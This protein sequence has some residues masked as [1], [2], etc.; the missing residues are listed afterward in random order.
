MAVTICNKCHQGIMSECGGKNKRERMDCTNYKKG[1]DGDCMWLR[2]EQFC[3]N[4]KAQCEC[5]GKEYKPPWDSS[6]HARKEK[7]QAEKNQEQ[8]D[9]MKELGE[10]IIPT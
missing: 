3:D 1:R 6:F 8:I 9:E 7:T 2:F 5:R 4:P 10:T